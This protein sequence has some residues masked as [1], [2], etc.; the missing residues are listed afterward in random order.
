MVTFGAVEAAARVLALDLLLGAVE[1]RLVVDLRFGDARLLE[2]VLEVV[3]GEF[4]GA[5]DVDRGDRGRS[6]T[7]TMRMSPSDSRRTSE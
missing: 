3:L 5:L 6:W 2:A 7:K 4:L 1:E